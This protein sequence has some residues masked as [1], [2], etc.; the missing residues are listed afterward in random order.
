MKLKIL[1]I[2]ERGVVDRERLHLSVLADANLAFYVVFDTTGSNGEI[3]ALPKRAYWFSDYSVSAGD[4]VILYTTVGTD[5][6]VKRKDGATNHFFYWG[7]KS[8]LW[9]A[10][11]SCA[12]VLEV[13]DWEASE[14]GK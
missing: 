2:I 3:L 4:H 11:G 6:S 10:K 12:V 8:P 13:A 7:F 9:G 5:K 14:F 1:Q